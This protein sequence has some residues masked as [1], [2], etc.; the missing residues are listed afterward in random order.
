[1]T[2]QEIIAKY[3]RK[4]RIVKGSLKKPRGATK[5]QVTIECKECS[6]KFPCYTSDLWIGRLCP[7]CGTKQGS[8]KKGAK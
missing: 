1:M 4:I 2:E 7:K 5:N 3:G 6:H 8:A